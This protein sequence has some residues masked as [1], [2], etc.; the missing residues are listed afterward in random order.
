MNTLFV[1][2]IQQT[3]DFDCSIAA[4]KMV[5]DYWN[6]P[7]PQPKLKQDLSEWINKEERHIQGAAIYLAKRGYEVW[8][9]H[10]DPGVI[11]KT[12]EN[13]NE[14]EKEKLSE[15]L[16]NSSE[17]TSD[18]RK[19]KVQL[20]IEYTE[21]G[22][23]YSTSIPTLDTLDANIKNGI[24]IIICVNVR[25]WSSNPNANTNHYVVVI[26]KE[27]D[28]YIVND[29]SPK[30]KN[31]YKVNENKL[32]MAWYVTGAYTLAALLK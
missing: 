17:K 7:V 22:G 26:G 27:N 24:P 1:P 14:S 3:D 8:F 19:K 25:V 20:D 31:S 4:L 9:T 2:L 32:L 13:I 5:M 12:T 29:P 28:D 30:V 15:V 10:H 6:D 16:K 21:S 18:F 23:H 11:D